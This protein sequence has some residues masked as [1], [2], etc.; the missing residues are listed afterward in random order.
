MF[1]KEE[2]TILAQALANAQVM[3]GQAKQATELLD[4][5]TGLIDEDKPKSK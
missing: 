2:L 4:K 5:V 1:T 3:V